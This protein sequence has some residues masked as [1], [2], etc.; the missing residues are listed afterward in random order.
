MIDSHKPI[1]V[2]FCTPMELKFRKIHEFRKLSQ[3]MAKRLKCLPPMRETWVWSLG[4]EDPLEKEMVNHSSILAWRI[5]WTEKPGELQS[6]GS[7][8][9]G[10]NWVTSLSLS[11]W[12]C[13]HK[14]TGKNNYGKVLP[15]GC[16]WASR[17]PFFFSFFHVISVLKH[18]ASG[19]R[20]NTEVSHANAES[21]PNAALSQPEKT[22]WVQHQARILPPS[23]TEMCAL[24]S[25]RQSVKQMQ[26]E[27]DSASAHG[28]PSSAQ[29]R[30]RTWL[31]AVNLEVAFMP[32]QPRSKRK[33]SPLWFLK[34]FALLAPL[35]PAS[36][37]FG[38]NIYDVM[39]H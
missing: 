31:T 32:N 16:K 21:T 18:S 25:W 30:T 27:P 28:T 8:R 33:I 10:H 36:S 38:L 14:G 29:L 5:P 2:S 15:Q 37:S 6:M 26:S 1:W 19:R 17:L 20:F 9:V 7:Q 39:I 35:F 23:S 24:A 11:L 34:W 4:R 12:V 3:V 13:R 22:E